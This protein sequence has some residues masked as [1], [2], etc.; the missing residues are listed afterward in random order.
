MARKS[1]E[2]YLGR[3]GSRAFGPVAWQVG[4]QGLCEVPAKIWAQAGVKNQFPSN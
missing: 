4:V 1:F 2:N 3:L